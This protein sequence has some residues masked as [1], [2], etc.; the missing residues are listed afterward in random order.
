MTV[1]SFSHRMLLTAGLLFGPCWIAEAQD[2]AGQDGNA[3]AQDMEDVMRNS[4]RQGALLEGSEP[5]LTFTLEP[6]ATSTRTIVITNT[7]DERTTLT[8]FERPSHPSLTFGGSCSRDMTLL[9]NGSC[10]VVVTAVGPVNPNADIQRILT[11]RS[12]AR[13]S[14]ELV[15]PITLKG[16]APPA[17]VT[18]PATVDGN[19]VPGLPAPP[20]SLGPAVPIPSTPPPVAARSP[21]EIFAE[22]LAA[23]QARRHNSLGGS[24][25]DRGS[26]DFAR[27][28]VSL[29]GPAAQIDLRTHDAR[30]D[31]EAFPWSETSLNVDR[32]R[33]LTQDRIIKVVLERP[34]TNVMCNQV[35]GVIQNDVYAP[36]GANV[37]LPRGTRFVGQ[38]DQFTDERAQIIWTRFITPNGVSASLNSPTTD[39]SGFGGAPGVLN[40]RWTERLGPPLA[41]TALG[42]ALTYFL[43]GDSSTQIT[44]TDN[45]TTISDNR[46][47]QDAAVDTIVQGITGAGAQIAADLSA[48][49]QVL[50]IPAGT[51]LD[52]QLT[53][54]LY[55]RSPYEVVSLDGHLYA[56]RKGGDPNVVQ[57]AP[58]PGAALI[59]AEQ[60]PI[61]APIV[62]LEGKRYRLVPVDAAGQPV[63]RLRSGGTG[64]PAVPASNE[65]QS[66]RPAERQPPVRPETSQYP[67]PRP[68]SSTVIIR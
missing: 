50:T 65:D 35:T 20:P 48:V 47:S 8:S 5:D 14:P 22:H 52:V 41:L 53:Q 63:N 26:A 21:R 42:A 12:N 11:V 18:P 57:P 51:V 62:T 64:S 13:R 55:F 56:L 59:P 17:P 4:E 9:E 34:F 6:G 58:A 29:S 66:T 54:D 16:K 23:A 68:G 39:A 7:G 44:A 45:S 67:T 30:Y 27:P 37:L 32:S 3:S 40:R 24:S 60:G 19:R 36:Q 10:S 1:R 15:I 25:F 43:A 28:P 46:S 61:D 31:E 2:A 38:C 33:I 49:P